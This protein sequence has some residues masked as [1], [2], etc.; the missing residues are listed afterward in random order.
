MIPLIAPLA[1]IGR[2]GGRWLTHGSVLI[3]LSVGYMVAARL[4]TPLANRGGFYASSAP[5]G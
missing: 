3:W 5:T 1:D 2:S 4:R